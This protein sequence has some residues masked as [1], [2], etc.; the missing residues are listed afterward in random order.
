MLD[1]TAA[2]HRVKRIGR[3]LLTAL[4]CLTRGAYR[5]VTTHKSKERFATDSTLGCR[6][7]EMYPEDLCTSPDVLYAAWNWG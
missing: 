6:V 5:Q 2:R 3:S 7:L 1:A 4:T